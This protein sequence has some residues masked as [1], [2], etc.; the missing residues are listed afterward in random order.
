M[1]MTQE[2]NMIVWCRPGWA[3]DAE[4]YAENVTTVSVRADGVV[5]TAEIQG[6]I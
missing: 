4:R 6:K 3:S 2:S 1:F 5:G